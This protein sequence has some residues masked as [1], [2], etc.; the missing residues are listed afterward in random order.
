MQA[1]NA[2]PNTEISELRA[3]V[4]ALRERLD[5]AEAQCA[6]RLADCERRHGRRRLELEDIIVTLNRRLHR[7][8]A[9]SARAHAPGNG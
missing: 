6:R 5:V 8:A 2:D 3:A 9:E 1:L 7:Q 4:A